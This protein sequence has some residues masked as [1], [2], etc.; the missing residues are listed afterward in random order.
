MDLFVLLILLVA[1]LGCLNTISSWFLYRSKTYMWFANGLFTLLFVGYWVYRIQQQSD[2]QQS[3]RLA[4]KDQVFQNSNRSKV[5]ESLAYHDLWDFY[6]KDQRS[7]DREE[8]RV[9]QVQSVILLSCCL[10]IVFT[11]YRLRKAERKFPMFLPDYQKQRKFYWIMLGFCLL[12]YL[13]P[14]FL[15]V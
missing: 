1:I 12:V 13:M 10:Q 4:L 11:L 3:R 15:G 8:D 7:F 6:I 9:R 2:L 14:L 5:R